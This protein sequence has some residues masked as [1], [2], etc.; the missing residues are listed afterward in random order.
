MSQHTIS[1]TGPQSKNNAT[2]KLRVAVL[3]VGY[4]GR[5]HARIYSR[6]AN[7]ELVGVVDV[8]QATA[9][10]VADE[11][12]CSAYYN[13]ADVIGRIDAASVV[14][15]TS[16]HW[17]AAQPLLENGVHIL[18]E[19]PIASSLA[20]G[21]KI[22][23]AAA[24]QKLILQV[25]H[26]ERFNAGVMTL[27]EYVTN[28]R[29]IEAHRLGTFVGRA[30]DVDVITDLMI[31]DIDIVISL[32]QAKLKSVSAVG[33]PVVTE[34]MDIANARLVFENGAVA[35][36]TASRVS[37]KK[38][39]RIRVFAKQQY[40]TLNFNNQQLEVATVSDRLPKKRFPEILYDKIDVKQRPPLDA[41]LEHFVNAVQTNTPPLVTGE[42]GMEAL[43]VAELV[44]A[45]IKASM[46]LAA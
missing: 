14:V 28:P 25:G 21:Q 16:E 18:M 17:Q 42:H 24:A 44:K 33:S 11:V 1:Q 9:K 34:H 7:V 26:S 37:A 19:K 6:M 36:V 5:I 32:V 15:P 45:E 39:R 29:F 2:P 12:G 22:V 31:H 43:R 23:D 46:E 40:I 35:N 10:E 13:A 20:Q 8:N 4:L 3:G 27:S 41:E 30:A 38:L